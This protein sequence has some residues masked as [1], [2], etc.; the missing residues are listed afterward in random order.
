MEHKHNDFC[1]ADRFRRSLCSRFDRHLLDGVEYILTTYELAEHSMFFV[2]MG[3]WSEGEIPLRAAG[4]RY[5]QWIQ[6][7]L[8]LPISS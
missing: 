3:C 1:Y 6:D 4:Y 5:V 8:Y 7:A 2:E